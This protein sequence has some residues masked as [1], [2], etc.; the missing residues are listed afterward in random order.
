MVKKLRKNL[1]NIFYQKIQ[2]VFEG[3]DFK[4]LLVF[5]LA[6]LSIPSVVPET[7]TQLIVSNILFSLVFLIASNCLLLD[8]KLFYKG[9]IL[10]FIATIC[11]WWSYFEPKNNQLILVQNI[12]YFFFFSV[13]LLHILR[14]LFQTPQID[15]NIVFG[16]MNGYIII[17]LLGSFL[18]IVVNEVYPDAYLYNDGNKL[19]FYDYIY[20]SFVNMTTLGFGDIVPKK[21]PAKGLTVIHTLIG[22]LYLSVLVGIMVGKF[23][24]HSSYKK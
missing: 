2:Q 16:A 14:T 12:A 15:L 20:F 4:I 5:L 13:L 18:M 24:A 9:F 3:R 10:G 17:G 8:R 19:V 11:T 21:T 22:Q 23:I 6:L 7:V 1:Q